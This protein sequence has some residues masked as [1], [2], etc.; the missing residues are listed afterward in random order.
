[1]TIMIELDDKKASRNVSTKG[2]CAFV[3][4]AAKFGRVMVARSCARF[5]TVVAMPNRQ[6]TSA[7]PE[8]SEIHP[9]GCEAEA[10]LCL[11]KS[12]RGPGSDV[13]A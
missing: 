10:E 4:K 7:G 8:L 2:R 12:E 11:C 9:A 6:P 1:M 13:R 3:Q 5:E